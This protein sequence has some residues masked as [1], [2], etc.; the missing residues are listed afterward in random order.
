MLYVPPFSP[1]LFDVLA[2]A[3]EEAECWG[4]DLINPELLLLGLLRRD[5]EDELVGLDRL[6]VDAERVRGELTRALEPGPGRLEEL[7]RPDADVRRVMD[8]AWR[9]AG[10]MRSGQ[11]CSAHLSLALVLDG[12][13]TASVCL[14]RHAIDPREGWTRTY[15]HVREQYSRR[16]RLMRAIGRF[17]GIH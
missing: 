6:E 15:W 13:C 14:A 17:I 11:V 9:I 3:L 1:D 5:E 4:H 8:R 2:Y 16:R 7:Y 12:Q 10:E